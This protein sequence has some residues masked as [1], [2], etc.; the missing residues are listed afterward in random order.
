M[1]LSVGKIIDSLTKASAVKNSI[2]I[3]FQEESSTMLSSL[4]FYL[5]LIF[6][7]QTVATFIRCYVFGVAGERLTNNL[8]MK[9][10]NSVVFQEISFF[11]SNEMGEILNRLSYDTKILEN[12]ITNTVATLIS[13]IIEILIGSVLMLTISW[14]LSI[15]M[16]SITPFALFILYI[17]GGW[18]NKTSKTYS[19]AIAKPMNVANETLYNIRTVRSF[20]QEEKQSNL[21]LDLLNQSFE[22]GKKLHFAGGFTGSLMILTGNIVINA[23]LW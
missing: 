8:R 6:M 7:V 20:G 22:I 23:L 9:L 19:D 4:S 3:F 1:P 15:M 11:D 12:V 13:R 14:R 17:F 18:Y 2:L 16:L 5:F 10:F 21:Y